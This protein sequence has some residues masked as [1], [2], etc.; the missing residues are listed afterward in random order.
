[1]SY[2]PPE[3]GRYNPGPVCRADGT[4]AKFRIYD[5]AYLPGEPILDWRRKPKWCKPWEGTREEAE[6]LCRLLNRDRSVLGSPIQSEM[7][8]TSKSQKIW[9]MT[10]ARK[11]AGPVGVS[12]R[13]VNLNATGRTV[14]VTRSLF[15]RCEQCGN[16]VGGGEHSCT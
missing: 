6:E 8:V 15:V 1:M 10:R 12:K 5:G 7:T 9:R 11:K 2:E 3:Y 16:M 13:S 4:H 14:N